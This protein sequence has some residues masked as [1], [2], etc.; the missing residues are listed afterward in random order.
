MATND[1]KMTADEII[2]TLIKSARINLNLAED[3]NGQP[4]YYDANGDYH[5]IVTM[6]DYILKEITK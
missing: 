4:L 1:I 6:L 2:V 3:I 5:D